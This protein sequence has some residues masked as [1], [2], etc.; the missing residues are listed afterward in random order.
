MPATRSARR[1]DSPAAPRRAALADVTCRGRAPG[2]A[3]VFI[4]YEPDSGLVDSPFAQ[5]YRFLSEVRPIVEGTA[6]GRRSPP[7]L[8][9]TMTCPRAQRPPEQWVDYR[10]H[11]L[12]S[13]QQ[14]YRR[15]W[16]HPTTRQVRASAAT[17]PRRTVTCSAARTHTQVMARVSNIMCPGQYDIHHG[18]GGPALPGSRG[19]VGGRA[20]L[21]G[22]TADDGG[23]SAAT[24]PGS[25]GW[26]LGSVRAPA[27][28]LGASAGRLCVGPGRRGG[29]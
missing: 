24:G 19:S 20:A 3:Q 16:C 7:T 10:P 26:F 22:E 21:G 25:L 5:W 29:G 12:R 9:G 15:T 14:L 6:G 2:C 17:A 23:F 27:G 1:S 8:R 18:W 4:D 11:V 13:F 28:G